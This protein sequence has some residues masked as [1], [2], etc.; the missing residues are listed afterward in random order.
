MDVAVGFEQVAEELMEFSGG[1]VVGDLWLVC[2]RGE[3]LQFFFQ[4]I[5]IPVMNDETMLFEKGGKRF[6]DGGEKNG[7]FIEGFGDAQRVKGHGICRG[8][9]DEEEV[10]GVDVFFQGERRNLAEN[11]ERGAERALNGALQ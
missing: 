6:G 9:I 11:N 8:D 10:R 3:F 1:G 4:V 7:A 2:G 5:E